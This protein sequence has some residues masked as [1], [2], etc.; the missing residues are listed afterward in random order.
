MDINK[1]IGA[2]ITD[3]V[4]RHSQ[5]A[6]ARA[7]GV[8][9]SSV[10]HYQRGRRVPADFCVKLSD[11]LGVSTSWLLTGAGSP[12]ASEAMLQTDAVGEGMERMVR[13]LGALEAEAHGSLKGAADAPRLGRLNDMLK[14]WDEAQ[15][16]L[17]ATLL[18]VA[19]RLLKSMTDAMD[20]LN[21]NRAADLRPGLEYLRRFAL[22]ADT[23]N[24]MD[25]VLSRFAFMDMEYER[26]FEI[27][28]RI[29]WRYLAGGGDDPRRV[30]DY[31]FAVVHGAYGIGR[32]AEA[33]MIADG[34]LAATGFVPEGELHR[35]R[36]RM[37]RASCLVDI[38]RITEAVAELSDAVPRLPVE[39]R[40]R[41]W[42][43]YQRT[44]VL[45]GAMQVGAA[46]AVIEN[47]A[48]PQDD[49]ALFTLAVLD[50]GEETLRRALK[51]AERT[52][53]LP[54]D[55]TQPTH[56]LHVQCLLQAM[57]GKWREA[58]KRWLDAAANLKSR[59]E[60]R[61]VISFHEVALLRVGGQESKARA[62]MRQFWKRW[63]AGE[64]E[65]P[66]ALFHQ[67]NVYH[68]A[69]LLEPDGSPLRSRAN[70][71]VR[72]KLRQGYQY[73]RPWLDD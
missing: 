2:R 71:W 55:P 3:L 65:L 28:R 47:Y 52:G 46:F 72:R 20:R 26:D 7:G 15:E 17:N 39:L 59:R 67:A 10:Y 12:Q 21:V 6:V 48:S 42:G 13:I 8:D 70:A 23:I 11:G 40:D 44:L 45:A 62:R 1:G 4:N 43:H 5:A 16:R 31:G 54:P 37:V 34:L 27:R 63:D 33:V 9:E 58:V 68:E 57:Q 18:P 22:P 73:F 25:L 14:T 29:L 49:T 53:A 69:I 24:R 51:F 35:L 61:E 19:D 32:Y 60:L 30:L 41:S 66:T 64:S 50:G 36:V 56:A 38:G